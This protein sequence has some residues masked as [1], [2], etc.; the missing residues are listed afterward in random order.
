MMFWISSDSVV[1]SPFSILILLI[2][3]LSLC[4]LVSLSRGLSVLL[5]FSKNQLLVWL[6]LCIVL[7]V[8]TSLVSA[9]S[10]FI[11]WHLHLLGKFA[12][13]CC[14]AF[15][16][17]AVKLLMCALSGFFLEALG[18]IRFPISTAST[19]SHKFGYVGF[20]FIKL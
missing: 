9:L 12:S 15:N 20:I 5:I 16:R 18:A 17:Y 2:G 19:V 1:I 3:I 4:S 8:S 13:F 11:S 14:R 7:S 6:I 10:L